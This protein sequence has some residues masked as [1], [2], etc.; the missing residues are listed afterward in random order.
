MQ[1]KMETFEKLKDIL[2]ECKQQLKDRYKVEE[3]GI[4]GSYVRKEQKKRSDLD[5][6]VSFSETIDLF[7]FVELE[8]YLSN[9]LVVK[10]DLVM[11]D[12]LKTRLK[13][14]ILNEAVYV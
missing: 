9:I 11:K 7:M 2:V 5:V 4:F 12:S 6:L 13:E 1:I 10:V 3:I 8:N 14:R